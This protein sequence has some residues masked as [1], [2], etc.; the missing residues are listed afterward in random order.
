M[1][2][3]FVDKLVAFWAASDEPEA[4]SNETPEERQRRAHRG[5]ARRLSL[6]AGSDPGGRIVAGTV[7][8]AGTEI[9]PGALGERWHAASERLADVTS[10]VLARLLLPPDFYTWH[11][12]A[13]L[14]C[15]AT[16]NAL[17]AEHRLGSLAREVEL[18]LVLNLGE[19][20]EH[21]HADHFVAE[22]DLEDSWL[23]VTA[24]PVPQLIERLRRIRQEAGR[25]AGHGWIRSARLGFRP[26]WEVAEGRTGPNHCQLEISGAGATLRQLE[27]TVGSAS[28]AEA[29]ARFDFVALVRAFEVLE[30]GFHD[31]RPV[32]LMLPVHATTLAL[33]NWRD[34]Y[35]QLLGTASDEVYEALTLE[36]TGGPE[37]AGGALM[38]EAAELLR[39]YAESI[40][41][42]LA[43][44]LPQPLR[45]PLT[46]L[47]G[48][49]FDLG[50]LGRLASLRRPLAALTRY[51][52]RR[53]LA[54]YA[55]GADTIAE[56]EAA[57]DAGF[58]FIGGAAIHA[59]TSEPRL[60]GRLAPLPAKR[61]SR[62]AP[63]L[64]Q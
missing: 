21:F 27:R 59:R 60:L 56:A 38:G 45:L 28:A 54:T 63:V 20:A 6:L 62:W 44:D 9:L 35:L 1:L 40:V 58:T 34:D 57:R 12:D 43:P 61:P 55:L 25:P 39:D 17:V 36:V 11:D 32:S 42:R 51:A 5:F 7:Q 29:M 33:P 13:A 37:A 23:Q 53:G 52:K 2:S 19:D 10:A 49:S 8:V 26:L 4:G 24:D 30:P 31:H 22:L 16:P 47:D 14:I 3:G 50:G 18:S 15:F 46:K 48:V 64:P 41:A